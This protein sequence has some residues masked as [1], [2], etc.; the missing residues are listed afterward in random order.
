MHD[1]C[2]RASSHLV[3]TSNSQCVIVSSDHVTHSQIVHNSLNKAGSQPMASSQPASSIT[4]NDTNLGKN[5]CS[6]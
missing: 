6:I 3:R 2:A 5:L 4:T 1:F